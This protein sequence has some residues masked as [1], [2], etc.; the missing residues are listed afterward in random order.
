M[1][2]S[3]TRGNQQ[4]LKKDCLERDGY[5]CMLSGHYDPAAKSIFPKTDWDGRVGGTQLA[6]ILPFS[7][8]RYKGKVEVRKLYIPS[9]RQKYLTY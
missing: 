1:V 2:D 6:H 9:A 3:T 5:R 8:G 7:L 4:S